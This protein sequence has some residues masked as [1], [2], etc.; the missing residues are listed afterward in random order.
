MS[1][2]VE[3]EVVPLVVQGL[4]FVGY[5]ISHLLHIDA[6]IQTHPNVVMRLKSEDL[7]LRS[8]RKDPWK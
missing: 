8:E 4:R 1:R 6:E 2:G 5:L 3:A 7:L